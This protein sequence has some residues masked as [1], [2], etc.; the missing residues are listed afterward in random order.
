MKVLKPVK[1]NPHFQIKE[2]NY[3]TNG[4]AFMDGKWQPIINDCANGDIYC[5]GKYLDSTYMHRVVFFEK[6]MLLI[7]FHDK[8]GKEYSFYN[9]KGEKVFSHSNIQCDDQ[10]GETN[11]SVFGKINVEM[12]EEI[13]V[14]NINR[15]GKDYFFGYDY[16]DSHQYKG[17]T[18]E[19][20]VTKFDSCQ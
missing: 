16:S 8:E 19:E 1:N 15:F 13:A 20:V 14:V 5:A 7:G 18:F 2:T 4:Y 3:N 10:H 17:H 12:F 6:G 11:W 9:N